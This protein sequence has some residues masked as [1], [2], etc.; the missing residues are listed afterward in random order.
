MILFVLSWQGLCSLF[1]SVP[2]NALALTN[3]AIPHLPPVPPAETVR[4][5]KPAN[6]VHELCT[7]WL[8]NTRKKGPKTRK[9]DQKQPIFRLFFNFWPAHNP[10]FPPFS[11]HLRPAVFL[12]LKTN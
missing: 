10:T 12:A 2:A 5:P 7:N 11:V 6:D 4:R 9:N 1:G 3:P 8:Q